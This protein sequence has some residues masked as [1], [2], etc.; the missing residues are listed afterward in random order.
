VTEVAP[1]DT[2]EQTLSKLRERVLRPPVLPEKP[3]PYLMDTELTYN[4]RAR[5]S[6]VGRVRIRFEPVNKTDNGVFV[7]HGSVNM[8]PGSHARHETAIT[9]FDDKFNAIKYSAEGDEAGEV[10][11]EYKLSALHRKN[12]IAVD[13]QRQLKPRPVAGQPAETATDAGQED[14]PVPALVQEYKDPLKRVAIEEDD[15]TSEELAALPPVTTFAHT[16]PLSDGTCLYDFNRLEHLAA[17]AYRFPMPPSPKDDQPVTSTY[18]KVGLYCVR[19]NRADI[20]QFEIRPEIKPKL[21]ERQLR[22]LDPRDRNEPQLYFATS[23]HSLLNCR[24]LLTGEGR[25]LQLTINQGTGD[26]TYTLDDPIMNRRAELARKQ[27][28]QEGP[29]LLRPPWW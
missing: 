16:R 26:V 24:M 27:R 20:V 7:G 21:T 2:L 8:S 11:A 13:M 22:R 6:D 17:I 3:F 15:A 1:L 10:V 12:T 18:Q 14:K 19:Q 4:V 28:M 23:T 29:Q 5:D 9:F 25:I